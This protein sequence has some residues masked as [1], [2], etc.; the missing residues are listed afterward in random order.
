MAPLRPFVSLGRKRL[1]PSTPL[2]AGKIDRFQPGEI[3]GRMPEACRSIRG[4]DAADFLQC[5]AILLL[6]S[7]VRHDQKVDHVVG[8]RQLIK[9]A[10]C[11][12]HRTIAA[13]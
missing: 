10:A 5:E 11:G 3:G 8:V 6:L 9:A 7:E 2:A 1:G 4:E 13:R 12:G